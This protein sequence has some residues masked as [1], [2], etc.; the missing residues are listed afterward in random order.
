MEKIIV[1]FVVM[2][3]VSSCI[4]NDKGKNVYLDI[5]NKVLEQQIIEYE[6]YTES[7]NNNNSQLNSSKIVNFIRLFLQICFHQQII[8]I[9]INLTLLRH[10]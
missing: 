9:V 8:I 5:N 1:A 2:F 3:L 10:L 4:T 7:K 6:K